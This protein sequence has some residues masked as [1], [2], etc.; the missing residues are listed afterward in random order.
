MKKTP[1][2]LLIVLLAVYL[3]SGCVE[4]QADTLVILHPHSSDFASHV[5]DGFKTWYKE[6]TGRDITVDT[7]EKYSGDCWTDVQTWN[8][9]SPEADVWWGGGEFYFEQARSAELLVRYKV[10]EDANV[11]D[12]LGGWHLKDDSEANKDP[13]WYAAAISGF[14]II[15]NEEYITANKDTDGTF[16]P[17]HWENLT[18]PAFFGHISMC[19]PDASGSTLA[20]VKQILQYMSDAT[21]EI[22]SNTNVTEGWQYWLQLSGNVGT[23]TTSSSAVP[24]AVAEGNAG[25][26]ICIDYYA[27]DRMLTDDNIGFT[28]GGATTVSP[29]PAGI[30]KGAANLESAQK[31]MD[32][33]IGTE[34]QTLVGDYRTPANFKAD[35]A[36]HVP[37]AW[38]TSGT[39]TT[40][41][42]AISPFSPS[43]DGAIHSRVEAVYANY[44]VKNHAACQDAWEAINLQETAATKA[45]AL[46]IY[47]RLPSDCNGTIAGFRGLNYKDTT[48]I[49][50]WQN[51]GAANFAAAETAA[52]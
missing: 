26:G 9:T 16:V 24:T 18:D 41:F 17:T 19:D 31:F 6:D 8:G 51:E 27:L 45:A 11:K 34:G 20:A 39:P 5:I 13:M 32:Y 23:F 12:Y 21:T 38:E 47:N 48:T 44:I 50:N 35:T 42:P 2:K 40:S 36:D 30:I 15:Y 10:S 49:T 29:D 46:A 7:I 52:T 1:V 37:K 25:V 22:T 14:G 33:L 4:A 28:Y 43:L 3:L